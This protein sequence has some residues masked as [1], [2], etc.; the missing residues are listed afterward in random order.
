MQVCFRFV[1]K[2]YHLDFFDPNLSKDQLSKFS[3]AAPEA[4]DDIDVESISGNSIDLHL[5]SSSTFAAQLLS[6][7][8]VL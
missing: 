1:S 5:K 8:Y 6:I 4:D 3:M 7:F 2:D